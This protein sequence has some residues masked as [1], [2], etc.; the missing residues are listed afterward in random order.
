ML[1]IRLT[2]LDL[3]GYRKALPLAEQLQAI[4]WQTWSKKRS[5]WR[6]NPARDN[7][8]LE[9]R[10]IL[11]KLISIAIQQGEWTVLLRESEREVTAFD[12]LLSTIQRVHP[13]TA[14]TLKQIGSTL[15]PTEQ[16]PA[17]LEEYRTILNDI[18]LKYVIRKQT[19][20]GRFLG[21]QAYFKAHE[22]YLS[23]LE[24]AAI[25]KLGILNILEGEV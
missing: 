17:I 8:V 11:L 10:R 15:L 21:T 25:R 22:K 4:K 20:F 7:L 1:T 23:I 14:T 5:S 13:Q 12:D 9:E 18:D 19:E 24:R 2:T 16:V 3:R 6:R